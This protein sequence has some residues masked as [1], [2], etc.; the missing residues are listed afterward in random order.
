[1]NKQE[2]EE[3]VAYKIARAKE[4]LSEVELHIQNKLWITAVNRLYYAC[5]YAVGALLTDR[6]IESQTHSGTKQ[7]F[8]LH[9]IKPGIIKPESGKF[10]STIFSLR[11]TGD[12][13][14][15]ITFEEE[16]V[17]ALLAPA[18]DLITQIENIISKQ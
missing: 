12:Y 13:D 4:T 18:T 16:T 10:Y 8:S 7:M 15:F 17:N 1:M 5:F 3:L 11:Q 14:A 2:R 9:F 6:E